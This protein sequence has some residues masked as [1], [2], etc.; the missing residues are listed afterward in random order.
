MALAALHIAAA[1]WHWW[2][3]DDVALRMLPRLSRT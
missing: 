2:R 3:R 1:L